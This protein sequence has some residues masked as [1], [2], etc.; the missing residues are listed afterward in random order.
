MTIQKTLLKAI[1]Y[2]KNGRLAEAE[3]L[4]ETILKTDPHHPDANY[5]LGMLYT[6]K[7]KIEEAISFFEKA[8]HFDPQNKQFQQVL[9]NSKEKFQQQILDEQLIELMNQQ[10]YEEAL[11]LAKEAVQNN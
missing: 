10:R 11:V 3:N 2:H 6:Q 5:N 8:L 7:N 1:K 4:Y 9:A